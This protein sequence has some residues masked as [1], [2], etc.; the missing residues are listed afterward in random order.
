M[1]YAVRHP[2]SLW[3]VRAIYVVILG[4]FAALVWWVWWVW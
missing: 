1:A 4:G 2:P 3:L